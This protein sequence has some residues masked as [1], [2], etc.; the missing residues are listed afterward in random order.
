MQV[1]S[2]VEQ[3]DVTVHA[4]TASRPPSRAK[5]ESCAGLPAEQGVPLSNHSIAGF[6][7]S[8]GAAQQSRDQHSKRL[9]FNSSFRSSTQPGPVARMLQAG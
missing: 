9:D 6:D 8:A 2:F 1:R 3:R 5:S 7:T 4:P